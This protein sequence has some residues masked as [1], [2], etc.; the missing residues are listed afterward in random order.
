M[1]SSIAEFALFGLALLLALAS[2]LAWIADLLPA[3]PATVGFVAG[4]YFLVD[5]AR[6]RVVPYNQPDVYSN[7]QWT[8]R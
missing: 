8:R 6:D 1:P 4:V 5:L 2:P 3:F 7:G